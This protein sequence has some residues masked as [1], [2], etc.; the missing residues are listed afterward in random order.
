MELKVEAQNIQI[1]SLKDVVSLTKDMLT[2]RECE[3]KNLTERME[4]MDV[5]F[6]AEKD[7]KVLMERKME[8]SDKL[9]KDL[10]DEY[11]AQKEIFEVRKY[12]RKR[13]KILVSYSFRF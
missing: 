1:E 2:I 6:K 5:K 13:K 7:R 11:R 4:S 10:K 8:L 9:N 3:V 12:S